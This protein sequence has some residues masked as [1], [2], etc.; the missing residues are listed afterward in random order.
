MRWVVVVLSVLLVGSNGYWL[1][2]AL[3]AGV[4]ISYAQQR[5]YELEE[6]T[7]ELMA[8]LPEVAKGADRGQ[9]IAAASKL[10]DQEPFEKDG[11]TWVGRLGFRFDDNGRLVSVSPAWSYGEDDP[12]RPSP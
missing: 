11:C 10:T 4:T 6:A 9:I 1:Y 2:T 7:K 12:C 3:D 5:I 8:L